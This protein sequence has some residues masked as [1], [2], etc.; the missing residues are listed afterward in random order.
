MLT[1]K[2]GV[3]AFFGVTV[4][5]CQKTK[6]VLKNDHVQNERLYVGS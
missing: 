5:I 4:H 3:A 1:S 6:N 2:M